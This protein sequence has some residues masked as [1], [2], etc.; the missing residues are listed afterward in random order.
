[1][2]LSGSRWNFRP[3]EVDRPALHTNV[4]YAR[5]K[6]WFGGY[7]VG[8]DRC[9]FEFRSC[10]YGGRYGLRSRTST[11]SGR[12]WVAQ[13]FIKAEGETIASVSPLLWT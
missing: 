4:G 6:E 2:T 8:G 3:P 1:M 13:N 12:Y 5:D 10:V 7:G 9:A 11:S